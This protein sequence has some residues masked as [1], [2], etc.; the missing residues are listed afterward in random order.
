MK[1]PVLITGVSSG[2]GQEA[3]IYLM[4]R[5]FPVF[6]SVR[7]LSDA[8]MLRD[9][10]PTLFKPLVFDV[11]DKDAVQK[12][13]EEVEKEVKETG[14]EALVNNAGIAVSGPMQHVKEEYMRKQMEVNFFALLHITQKFLPLLGASKDS[15]YKPGR[16]INIS[17][18]SGRLVR[19]IMGPYSASKFAVE[20]ISD[21]LR[22]ELRIYGIKVVIIEP[23]P[24][25]TEI[26]EKAKV[27][28]NP[29]MDTD[30]AFILKK[31]DMAIKRSQKIAV[32]AEDVAKK[33]YEGITSRSP[34]TRY[35]VVARKWL[36]KLIL[37]LAPTKLVDYLFT[38]EAR[39]KS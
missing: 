38:M 7:A 25:D 20:A 14:L 5:G 3:A 19:I 12:A 26:W 18:L 36:I 23:G 4:D 32:P 10:Y 9:K 28:D 8:H 37:K 33:I 6:G 13:F 30:Y 11:R 15:P 27:E 39:K 34:K 1:R 21:A 16:L 29:Y 31:R 24:I 17:S 2:I 22:R 35:I